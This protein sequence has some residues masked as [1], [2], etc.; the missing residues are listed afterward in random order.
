MHVQPSGED[1][2]AMVEI[3]GGNLDGDDLTVHQSPLEL[4]IYEYPKGDVLK[5]DTIG[6]SAKVKNLSNDYD[7]EKCVMKD[8]KATIEV[9]T[10]MA[11]LAMDESATKVLEEVLPNEDND[12]YGYSWQDV[13]WTLRCWG[14]GVVKVR[15]T[16]EATRECE[17]MGGGLLTKTAKTSSLVFFRQVDR[18]TKYTICMEKNWNLISLPVQPHAF[19]A[20]DLPLM[21]QI[22]ALLWPIKSSLYEV[23][24][25]EGGEWL[26]FMYDDPASDLT[27]MKAGQGYFVRMYWPDCLEGQGSDHCTTGGLGDLPPEYAVDEGWNLI[28]VTICDC[29]KDGEI[30]DDDVENCDYYCGLPCVECEGPGEIH[31]DDDELTIDK[32]LASMNVG[33]QLN[34]GLV[35]GDEA[36]VVR[37]WEPWGGFTSDPNVNYKLGARWH[38]LDRCEPLWPG[39]GYWMK[40][41]LPG[42]MIVP[43]VPS[44]DSC[45]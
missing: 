41:S 5:G 26:R 2:T 45:D 11:V 32:Y 20:P 9:E 8:V 24:T 23:W 6:I 3:P 43:P 27:M 7:C 4:V 44:Q 13:E 35:Y 14:P 17:E 38:A 39:M 25:Y 31:C 21:D 15:V 22:E 18:P 12:T 37:Y 36:R 16:V 42:L 29:D 10:G 30:D 28:G 33:G 34:D 40:A 19:D 1:E